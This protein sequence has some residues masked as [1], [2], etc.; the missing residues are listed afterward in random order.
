[1]DND[2]LFETTAST[3]SQDAAKVLKN[4]YMLL[5]MTLVFSAFTAFVSMMINPPAFTYLACVLGSFVLTFFVE[6]NK[7]SMAGLYLTFAIT[8]LLGFALGP[9]LNVY[10]K[11]ANGPTMIMT[12]LGGTALIVSSL[13]AYTLITK[14]DFSFLGGFLFVGMMVALVSIAGFW[15]AGLF[16]VYIPTLHLALSAGII[17]LMSGFILYDTSRII[18]GGERNYISATVSLYLSIFNIFINLLSILGI[19]SDD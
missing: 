9:I 5:S 2:Q 13:S 6:K 16:G 15:I 12:A 4:T 11:L 1:M 7:N 17:F 10:L 8:G 14:K 3:S 19:T 18:N